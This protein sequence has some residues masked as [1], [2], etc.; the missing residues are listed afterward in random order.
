MHAPEK[1]RAGELDGDGIDFI[2]CY[3]G[4]LPTEVGVSR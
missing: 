2:S 4:R 1:S 3:F